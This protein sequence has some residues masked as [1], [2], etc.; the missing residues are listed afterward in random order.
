MADDLKAVE[1]WASI[2]THP[3]KLVTTAGT[4]WELHKRGI[5]NDI[6]QTETDFSTGKYFEAGVATADAL[7]LLLGPVYPKTVQ[8][9]ALPGFTVMEIPD[10]VAGLLY[11]WTGDNNLTEIE[12]CYNSD[13]PIL[14]DF[15]SSL[16]ELFNGHV[17][18]SVELFEKGI[19][20]LQI[21]MEPC[22]AMQD[23]IAALKAWSTMFKE[24]AHLLE[25]V[26]THWELHKRGIKA[27]IS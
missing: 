22:H 10:F 13:L 6:T 20:N 23:D 8:S 14:K 12:A 3:T 25:V 5:K 18:K 9:N 26:G 2:F 16:S 19:F 24:P 17:I 11:G 15:S 7:E 21:A 4:H 27:D 1:A